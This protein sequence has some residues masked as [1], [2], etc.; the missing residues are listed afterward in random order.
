MRT[1][2]TCAREARERRSAPGGT[3]AAVDPVPEIM[4]ALAGLP[5]RQRAA[6]SSSTGARSH[7]RCSRYRISVSA[8]APCGST[9]PV[10]GMTLRKE[11]SRHPPTTR[12]LMP[13]CAAASEPWPPKHRSRR[14][15]TSSTDTA[16]P[17]SG[18]ERPGTTV[19]AVAAVILVVVTIGLV[20]TQRSDHGTGS[21]P[22]TAQP[23][24]PLLPRQ[25]RWNSHCSAPCGC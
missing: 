7:P 9:S 3:A 5:M 14:A 18:V 17:P 2:G 21:R 6:C 20:A 1:A 19:L 13:G 15:S 16:L 4:A 11:L 8:K 24:R 23:R 10:P 25:H 12:I 22:S